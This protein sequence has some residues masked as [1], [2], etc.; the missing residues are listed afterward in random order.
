MKKKYLL[1]LLGFITST[2]VFSQT[3]LVEVTINTPSPTCNPGDCTDLYASFTH[4]EQTTDYA[5]TPIT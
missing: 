3:P 1:L 4:L 2:S 5:V